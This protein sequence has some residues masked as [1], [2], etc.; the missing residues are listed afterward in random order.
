MWLQAGSQ[1]C[2]DHTKTKILNHQFVR[3]KMPFWEEI[4]RGTWRNM[5]SS[6]YKSVLVN[7]ANPFEISTKYTFQHI[8]QRWTQHWTVNMD[9]ILN[10]KSIGRVQQVLWNQL[11]V[12]WWRIFANLKNVNSFQ[13]L[14]N[15]IQGAMAV[16]SSSNHGTKWD[17]LPKEV[18]E[19]L[20]KVLPPSIPPFP[21]TI[22]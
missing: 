13:K 12:L 5:I 4:K 8:P 2:G 21:P 9:L 1:Q 14:F 6:N 7:H 3:A 20:V 16:Y 18:L 17:S 22:Q 11:F 19:S 10:T 15:M